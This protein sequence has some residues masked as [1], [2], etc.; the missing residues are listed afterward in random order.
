MVADSKRGHTRKKAFRIVGIVCFSILAGI[1]LLWWGSGPHQPSDAVLERRFN[2][3]RPDFDRLLTM[4]DEDRNMSRIAPDFTWRQ[5]NV[6]WPRPESEWG[7][8]N[9][10]W[11]DYKR[12]FSKTGLDDG[13]TKPEKSSDTLLEVWSWGLVVGGIRVSYL[14]CGPPRDGSVHTEP[15]CLQNKDSGRVEESSGDSYR[16]KKIAPDWYIFEESN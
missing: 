1:S 9:E 8:S 15:P 12:L 6:A 4:M 16:F 3:E 14:H 13:I 11:N 10:R 7:I 5:D 2:K